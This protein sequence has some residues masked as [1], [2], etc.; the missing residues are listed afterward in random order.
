M[1]RTVHRTFAGDK[2]HFGL[3]ENDMINGMGIY[4]YPNGRKYVGEFWGGVRNGW[5]NQLEPNGQIMS[6][7]F[8]MDRGKKL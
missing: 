3:Y 2:V 8:E 7:N 1:G 6:G 5:G 4:L